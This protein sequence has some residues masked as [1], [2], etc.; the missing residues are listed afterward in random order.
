MKTLDS[1]LEECYDGLVTDE[2]KKRV[3]EY[4]MQTPSVLGEHIVRIKRLTKVARHILESDP[5]SLESHLERLFHYHIEG[6]QLIGSMKK[7]D[8]KVSIAMEAHLCS[9][10]AFVARTLSMKNTSSTD[11]A[12]FWRQQSYSYLITSAEIITNEDPNHA[13]RSYGY[14]A[15]DAKELWELT[16]N[17][18]WVFEWYEKRLIAGDIA[19]IHNSKQAIYHYSFAANGAYCMFEITQHVPWLIKS[20]RLHKLSS[21]LCVG[22]DQKHSAYSSAFAADHAMKLP[23]WQRIPNKKYIG[24]R[25]N[26]TADCNPY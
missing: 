6:L 10:A 21:D 11:L 8:I 23:S 5:T 18:S 19:A 14:A 7:H 15:E 22:L 3:I 17:H 12:I 20:Q 16:G 1:L 24:T 4:V 26:I 2:C 13:A 25:K 9:H